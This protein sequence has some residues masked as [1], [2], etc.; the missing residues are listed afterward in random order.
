MHQ[1]AVRTIAFPFFAPRFLVGFEVFTFLHVLLLFEIVRPVLAYGS[2]V[3]Q[4]PLATAPRRT[5]AL[6]RSLHFRSTVLAV[7]PISKDIEHLE[8]CAGSAKG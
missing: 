8:G 4:A 6:S 3:S 1:G 5:L 2:N 7:H